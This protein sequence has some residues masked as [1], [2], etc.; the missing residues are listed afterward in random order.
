[1]RQLNSLRA[2]TQKRTPRV[3]S[4]LLFTRDAAG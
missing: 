3:I 1:L 2:G 4:R